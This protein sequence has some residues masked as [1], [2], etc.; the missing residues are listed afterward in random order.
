MPPASRPASAPRLAHTD[1]DNTGIPYLCTLYQQFI[2]W[3]LFNA[4]E[5]VYRKPPR[6][7][8]LTPQVQYADYTLSALNVRTIDDV[9]KNV[10]T[11]EW[12]INQS[13]IY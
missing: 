9:H 3:V 10:D 5:V 13:I 2:P 1:V 11:Q 6:F 4:G 7:N 12:T 8:R